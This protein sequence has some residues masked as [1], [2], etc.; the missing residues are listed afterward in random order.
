MIDLNDHLSCTDNSQS[1]ETTSPSTQVSSQTS[2]SKFYN[3]QKSLPTKFVHL[4]VRADHCMRTLYLNDHPPCTNNS[5]STQTTS[6]S[7]QVSR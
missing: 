2:K 3:M 1:T 7:T 5:R 4:A 6:Q